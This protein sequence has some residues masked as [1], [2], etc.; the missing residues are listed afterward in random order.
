MLGGAVPLD[1]GM[2]KMGLSELRVAA[3]IDVKLRAIDSFLEDSQ[4]VYEY[5]ID[6]P[7]KA[8]EQLPGLFAH[9]WRKAKT[10][11]PLDIKGSLLSKP[12]PTGHAEAHDWPAQQDLPNRMLCMRPACRG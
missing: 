2:L 1:I 5:Y 8:R 11:L 6:D 7:G 9:F 4:V 3:D 10:L 12:P